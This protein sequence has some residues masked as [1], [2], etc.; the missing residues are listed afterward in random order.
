MSL[1]DGKR[2]EKVDGEW[3]LVADPA[4]ALLDNTPRR[5]TACGLEKPA[6][7][8]NRSPRGRGGRQNKCRKCSREYQLA[9][10]ERLR[11]QVAE[12]AQPAPPPERRGASLNRGRSADSVVRDHRAQ[13]LALLGAALS[14]LRTSLNRWWEDTS[15]G[16]ELAPDATLLAV[17]VALRSA[18]EED[19][20]IARRRR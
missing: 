17:R 7:D 10:R 3:C 14:K 2:W 15:E 1:T 13:E 6:G 12:Q 9:Y 8:F 18:A 19:Q 16:L 20:R 11:R 4:L 5:C